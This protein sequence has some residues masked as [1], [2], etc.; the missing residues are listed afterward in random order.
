MK[1]TPDSLLIYLN[2]LHYV[3]EI[4]LIPRYC[5]EVH[6]N[7]VK[8]IKYNK[9]WYN[10]ARQKIPYPHPLFPRPAPFSPPPLPPIPAPFIAVSPP[11]VHPLLYGK[12]ISHPHIIIYFHTQKKKKQCL[13]DFWDLNV[14]F[15]ITKTSRH[16]KLSQKS[17]VNKN[18]ASIIRSKLT[19][20]I[21]RL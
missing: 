14:K 18:K 3:C 16:K 1:S 4:L 8:S 19:L 5:I 17:A 13:L 7:R 2:L 21:S 20:F 12:S 15:Y 10:L 6:K 9:F 11:P